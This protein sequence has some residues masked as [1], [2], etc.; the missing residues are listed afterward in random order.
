MV[1]LGRVMNKLMSFKQVLLGTPVIVGFSVIA[2]LN[3]LKAEAVNLKANF[4]LFGEVDRFGIGY[5]DMA[6]HFGVE[7][8]KL[9][10][11][12]K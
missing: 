7:I 11:T 12:A 8:A 3:P 4:R 2:T 10:R 9:T 6:L 1:K 5:G